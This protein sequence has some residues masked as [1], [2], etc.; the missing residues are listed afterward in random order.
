M[1]ARQSN[2][3]VEWSSDRAP[4]NNMSCAAAAT[5]SGTLLSKLELW[6]ESQAYEALIQLIDST[7]VLWL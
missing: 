7:R 3:Q 2:L 4:A 1:F 6:N 5:V